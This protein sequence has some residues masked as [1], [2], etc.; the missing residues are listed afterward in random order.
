MSQG[1]RDMDSLEIVTQAQNS[2]HQSERNFS[3]SQD[4]IELV[5]IKRNIRSWKDGLVCK[6][7]AK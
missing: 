5:F 3:T 1:H 6:M 4:E 7:L 2:C